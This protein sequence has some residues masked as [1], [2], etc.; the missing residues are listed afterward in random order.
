MWF[1]S[2]NIINSLPA[3]PFSWNVEGKK[4]KNPDIKVF[5]TS[6]S[7]SKLASDTAKNGFELN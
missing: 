1:G 2:T 4:E 5:G 6:L 7:L 3:A